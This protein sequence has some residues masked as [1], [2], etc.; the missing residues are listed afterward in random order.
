MKSI[1]TTSGESSSSQAS[2]YKLAIPGP[3]FKALLKV[4]L[5]A[6]FLIKL[7]LHIDQIELD[8]FRWN[9]VSFANG[10]L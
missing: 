6:F 5:P 1:T 9:A 2:G 10:P 7:Q 4:G 8:L 3:G